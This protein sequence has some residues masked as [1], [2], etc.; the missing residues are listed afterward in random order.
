MFAGGGGG[1]VG[2]NKREGAK[3]V[4]PVFF[5]DVKS[6][7]FFA[8]ELAFL[9]YIHTFFILPSRVLRHTR[10]L[11]PFMPHFIESEQGRMGAPCRLDVPTK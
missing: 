1:Q 3:R 9:V 5:R 2:G 6:V 8:E 11:S 4:S 7:A 10:I